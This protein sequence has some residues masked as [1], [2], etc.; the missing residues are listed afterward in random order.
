MIRGLKDV[1]ELANALKTA[2]EA[3]S[4]I[5]DAKK[6]IGNAVVQGSSSC[7][8]ATATVTGNGMVID[9]K[10]ER[11]LVESGDP[12]HV[13]PVVLSAITAAQAQAQNVVSD[14]MGRIF[15]DLGLPENLELPQ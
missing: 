2:K 13:S 12:E 15:R 1:G 8:L 7:G 9:L 6:E 10:I 4:R 14:R 3:Q 11:S 5:E